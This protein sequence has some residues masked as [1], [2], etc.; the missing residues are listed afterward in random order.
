MKKCKKTLEKENKAFDKRGILGFDKSMESADV[1]KDFYSCFDNVKS[2]PDLTATVNKD[3]LDEAVREHDDIMSVIELYRINIQAAS[4]VHD[5]L[6][7][8]VKKSV[9]QNT[10]IDHGYNK[11]GALI[12]NKQVLANMPAMAYND[13]V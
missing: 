6:M 2:I 9:S 12:S 3:L 8:S 1:L 10:K 13:R 4:N 7:D 11:A 5:I